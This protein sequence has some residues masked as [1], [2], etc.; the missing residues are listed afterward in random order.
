MWRNGLA[1]T[2][3][4]LP[5]SVKREGT[6]RGSLARAR[7]ARCRAAASRAQILDRHGGRA[8]RRTAGAERIRFAERGGDPALP[9]GRGGHARC[10]RRPRDRTRP[11][12]RA[13]RRGGD[14]CPGGQR[15][16]PRS[17]RGAHR[18]ERR[19]GATRR[20]SRH[21]TGR[22]RTPAHRTRPHRH[23]RLPRQPRLPRPERAAAE[24]RL[25]RDRHAPLPHGRPLGQAGRRAAA[26]LRG[27]PGGR[28]H[29]AAPGRCGARRAGGGHRGARGGGRG[30]RKCGRE[31]GDARRAIPGAT[32]RPHRRARLPAPHHRRTRAA[33]PGRAG[34]GTRRTRAARGPR[35]RHR[36]GS[37]GRRRLARHPAAAVPR[38]IQRRV[39]TASVDCSPSTRPDHVGIATSAPPPPPPA[40][41]SAST[42]AP[43]PTT[44]PPRPTTPSPAPEP[45][46]T[47]PAPRP[48]T[49]AP[50]PSAT[51]SPSPSPSQP[52]PP[53]PPPPP[54]TS[55]GEQALAWART[56]LGKPYIWGGVGP[57]GYDC[58]GLVQ[59]AFRN[60][61][62][63]LPRTTGAQYHATARVPVSQLRAGDLIFYSSNGQPSGI[64]HVAIY[65]GNGMRLHAPSP[66]KSVELVPMWWPDVLP[67]GGR[68]G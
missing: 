63:S 56:Q 10:D 68:V 9:A 13:A 47:T 34:A 19:R 15:G 58:S 52:P 41:P 62:V 24:R 4:V 21:R 44:P 26:A 65:A 37:G 28:H 51:P 22:T 31:R 48:T 50:T 8:G 1:S 35:G 3:R 46:P 61:G 39:R 6:F 53:P 2:R 36:G 54:S 38:D 18:S 33:A 49:P 27:S 16:L 40:R 45:E 17:R 20:P 7:P 59:M 64:R 14:P 12:Q 57:T 23:R 43:S 30:R 66:G 25:L 32:R 67:Y 42:P 60:A 29:P 11:P 55:T 5:E